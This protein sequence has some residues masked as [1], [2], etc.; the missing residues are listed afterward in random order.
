MKKPL[1]ILGA[2]A[3]ICA[4]S[5]FA[6]DTEET[7]DIVSI[8][9]AAKV[10]K[11]SKTKSNNNNL[12][13]AGCFCLDNGY[14]QGGDRYTHTCSNYSSQLVQRPEAGNISTIY[15]SGSPEQVILSY[16]RAYQGDYYYDDFSELYE[17]A[18][19]SY[20]FIKN[21]NKDPQFVAIVG[22]SD[23]VPTGE[24]EHIIT[25]YAKVF[26]CPSSY[27]ESEPGAKAVTECFKYDS[28]SNKI[29]F[30]KKI[31]ANKTNVVAQKKP[32]A[33]KANRSAPQMVE[34]AAVENDL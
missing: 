13:P 11:T 16:D 34:S 14:Y 33:V 28:N 32:S 26:E 23:F 9:R 7:S 5:A 31:S 6:I 24:T 17:G 18:F 3:S 27:P 4:T 1:L 2:I 20:G 10:K 12:C 21:G 19:G 25:P 29:Y 30:R 8:E 22:C 15:C